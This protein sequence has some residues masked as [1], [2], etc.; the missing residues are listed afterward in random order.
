LEQPARVQATASH[1]SGAFFVPVAQIRKRKKKNSFVMEQNALF[2]RN[3]H[4]TLPQQRCA[5]TALSLSLAKYHAQARSNSLQGFCEH[6]QFA[7]PSISRDPSES[8]DD[9]LLGGLFEN[10]DFFDFDPVDTSAVMHDEPTDMAKSHSPPCLTPPLPKRES[11]FVKQLR[12]NSENKSCEINA[13]WDFDETDLLIDNADIF[14]MADDCTHAVDSAK[15]PVPLLDPPTQEH[16]YAN[17]CPHIA[18]DEF[19]IHS[20]ANVKN[21]TSIGQFPGEEQYATAKKNDMPTMT[22]KR[23]RSSSPRP[24][25]HSS[26]E[27]KLAPKPLPETGEIFEALPL[28][29]KRP[30]KNVREKRR[31]GV[32]KDKYE[33]LYNLCQDI[34]SKTVSMPLL[35]IQD[36]ASK[37]KKSRQ[38]L[39]ILGDVIALMQRMAKELSELRTHNKRL[40]S[41]HRANVLRWICCDH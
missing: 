15:V 9:Q 27:L 6:S 7:K 12:K 39:E 25:F 31:R 38:K 5:S 16:Y 23:P 24:A 2:L 14:S 3:Y 11:A 18:S 29:R 41:Y 8:D 26:E 35:G 36:D 10:F 33:E 20:D 40:K 21:V 1:A 32:M 28:S 17:T 34:L 22:I 4:N 19:A 30:F 37:S 13:D